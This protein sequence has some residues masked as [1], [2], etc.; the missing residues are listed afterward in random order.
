MTK[1]ANTS[2]GRDNAGQLS[3]LLE[4]FNRK[5]AN[6]GLEAPDWEAW[7]GKIHTPGVVDK[8]KAK[9]ESFM[10]T[11]YDVNDA[12]SRVDT[13]TAKLDALEVSATYNYVLWMVHYTGH[14]QFLETLNALGNYGDLSEQ[15]V[16]KYTPEVDL[17]F[18]MEIEIGNIAPECYV[19]NGIATRI[20]T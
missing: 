20:A 10:D 7:N 16:M 12:V 6:Q 17:T 4:L 18:Q 19:E 11:T 2:E 14:L 8:I 3:A 1:A 5:S 9:Y 15:E 13:K